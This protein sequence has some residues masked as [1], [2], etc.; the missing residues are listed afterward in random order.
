MSID[1][2]SPPTSDGPDR[3]DRRARELLG[4]ALWA[5]AALA[6]TIAMMVPWVRAGALSHVSPLEV[7]GAL[8]AGAVGIP[9]AAGFAVL[10]VPLLSWVL[11]ALAPA[12]GWAAL[13]A[14]LVLWAA[15]SAAGLA[16]VVLLA[17]I[18]ASTYGVGAALVVGACLLGAGALTCSTLTTG[19]EQ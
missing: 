7:A 17:S 5:G 3:D 13:V 1:L 6:W 19:Q 8:R 4:C 9:S 16:L 11:L 2:T 18:S 12:R 14:R 10:L 15:S